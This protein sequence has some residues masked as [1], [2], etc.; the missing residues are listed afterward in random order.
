MQQDEMTYRLKNGVLYAHEGDEHKSA[1]LTLKAP[2]STGC[3]PYFKLKGYIANALLRVGDLA[4]RAGQQAEDVRQVENPDPA[5][6]AMALAAG[7][8]DYSRL[9]EAFDE[10]LTFVGYTDTGVLLKQAVVQR[11]DV[12]ERERIMAEYAAN[13][14]LAGI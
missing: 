13:F 14:I 5:Q 11:I 12:R 9:I 3:R 7:A 8:E 2:P 10:L 6:L 4:R 1:T